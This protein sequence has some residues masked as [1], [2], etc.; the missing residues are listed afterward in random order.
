[1][2]KDADSALLALLEALGERRYAFTTVTPLTHARVV[3]RRAAGRDL[4]DMLGWSL[5]VPTGT[6]A[7]IEDLLRQA[8][9]LR[10]TDG[11]VRSLVRVSGIGERL[12][13]HS[14]YPTDAE[15]SVF[16]GP[17]SY[18]FA[19]LIEDELGR[20]ALAPGAHIVDI[21]AGAGVGGIVAAGAC[22]GGRTTLTDINPRALR[23]ARI[24]ARAAG[25]AVET[26]ES[27]DLAEVADPIDLALANPPYIVD[28]GK[29]AY[30]DGGGLHGGALSIEMARMALDRLAPRGRLILYTGAAIVGGRNPVREALGDLAATRGAAFACREIDPDVFGEELERPAY[31]DAE[32]I[33]VIAA[34]FNLPA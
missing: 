16:F 23:F 9:Q 15:D 7:A 3:A 11:Q 30:R 24:N 26:M 5:P 6:D 34:I 29:R 18:R 31:A 33:A 2:T 25:V 4:R 12:F 21:G 8:G 32:R 27:G 17:D 19:R 28:D 22:G 20:A 14:A 13:L 1:M 10:E